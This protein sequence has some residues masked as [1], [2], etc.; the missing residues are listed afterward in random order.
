MKLKTL[1]LVTGVAAIAACPYTASATVIALTNGDFE[2]NSLTANGSVNAAPTGWTAVVGAGN[3]VANGTVFGPN[4]T[5]GHSSAQYYLAAN[6]SAD[7]IRQDTPLPWAS[8]SVGDTLTVSAWTSYRDTTITFPNANIAYFW[9]NN[10]NSGGINV[11]TDGLLGGGTAVAPG[12]WV[13]RSWTYTV[14]A[15][16]LADATDATPWGAVGVQLGIAISS[17]TKQVAF[18]DVTLTYTAVPEP[19]GL[20]LGGS[21]LALLLLCRKR[22][23]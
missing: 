8:L 11:T 21:G 16:D 22:R 19:S 5:S 18:D 10:L 3:Y 12:A 15:T 20:A 13:Q 2:T 14:T 6:G 23:A 1:A 7:V 17:G 4:L 9:L